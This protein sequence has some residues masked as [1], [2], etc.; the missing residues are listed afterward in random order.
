M[1]KA[2]EKE[3]PKGIIQE[4]VGMSVCLKQKAHTWE[5]KTRMN[6]CLTLLCA[7]QLLNILHG[8]SDPQNN[9]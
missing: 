7:R 9:V 6:A 1:N 3:K 4:R 5:G 8:L 2:K